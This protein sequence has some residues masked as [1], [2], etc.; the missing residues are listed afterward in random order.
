MS[1]ELEQQVQQAIAGN[2]QALEAVLVGVSDY[3]YN[4]SLKMLLFPADAQDATQE[5]LVRIM[6]HLCTFK[7]QSQFTTWV[8]RVATNY[9]ITARGK[10]AKEFAMDFDAYAQFIDSG[11]SD[12]VLTTANA[13]ELRLLEEEVKVSCTQGLLLC[14]DPTHR[15]AYILGDLLELS[16]KE[17]AE[18]LQ[19][20]PAA[21]RQQ[22]ARARNKVRHFM[23]AKC[24][25]VT[26]SNP[27]RCHKKID[28]LAKQQLIDAGQLKFAHLKQ[29]SLDL[30]DA[31][32]HLERVTALYRTNP[33][34]KAPESIAHS[35][36]SLL[37]Y[38]E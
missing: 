22:L 30:L 4:L 13:G 5:I 34:L 6:T 37:N 36:K 20:T 27:C 2:R 23:E 19:V 7:G 12:Q 14:L 26:A 8:Y 3:V 35:I 29:R 9:L 11:Q 17:G 10:L 18:V 24:G 33:D 38:A 16:S 1:Q 21:F 31:I 28:F 15:M 25:L 32:T